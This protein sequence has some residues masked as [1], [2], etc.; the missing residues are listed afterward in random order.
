MNFYQQTISLSTEAR[1]VKNV[2]GKVKKA[3]Q[4]S[5]IDE[6]FCLVFCPHTTAGVTINEDESGLKQDL[7][8]KFED[9]APENDN[10]SHNRG[11]EGNAHSHIIDVLTGADHVLPVVGGTLDMGTWQSVLFVETDGPR[12]RRLK[13]YVLGE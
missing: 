7:L 13:I 6:G 12:S 10:Y 1:E 11:H 9:L 8:A 2:T 4:E 5:D 3:V